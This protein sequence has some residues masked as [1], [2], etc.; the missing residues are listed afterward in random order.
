[1]TPTPKKSR[2]GIF[3]FLAGY[4]GLVIAVVVILPLCIF[5]A[6]FSSGMQFQHSLPPTSHDRWIAFWNEFSR[7]T[8]LYFV[9]PSGF[10][11]RCSR[12]FERETSKTPNDANLTTSTTL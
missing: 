12:H 7:A 6:W 3:F 4:T 9:V 8:V 11:I 1:M 5:S 2:L 10:L